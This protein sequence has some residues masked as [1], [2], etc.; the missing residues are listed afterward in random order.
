MRW[1]FLVSLILATA[2]F[3]HEGVKNPGV[4]A[5]MHA[6]KD[7][8]ADLKALGRMTLGAVPFDEKAAE[9]YLN[10][11]RLEAREIVTLFEGADEDPKSEALP[12]I[13]DNFEDF[14]KRARALEAYLAAQAGTVMSVQD[15]E[16]IFATLSAD[17]RACHKIY[18]E[19]AK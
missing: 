9:A 5:R 17:C 6:M 16:P 10:D 2:A 4:M 14:S 7:M 15:L 13:W 11:L 12:V 3:A 19:K 8:G 1:I 18:R